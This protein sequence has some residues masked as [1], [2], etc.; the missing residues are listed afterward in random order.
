MVLIL[1]SEEL[2][3]GRFIPC[4]TKVKSRYWGLKAE[5]PML[6]LDLVLV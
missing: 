5:N 2:S 1:N 6:V 3:C 4:S